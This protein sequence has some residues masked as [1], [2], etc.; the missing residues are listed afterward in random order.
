MFEFLVAFGV[1]ALFFVL[2]SLGLLI[3]QKPLKGS[4]G[5]VATLMGN[6]NCEICG[7]D[8]NKCDSIDDV[9]LSKEMSQLAKKA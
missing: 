6:D 9:Q 2:L 5:G 3:K 8:P 7:G 4:C 1:F